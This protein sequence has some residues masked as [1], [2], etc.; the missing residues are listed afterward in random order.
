LANH[1]LTIA[2]PG[3]TG[4]LFKYNT[5]DFAPSPSV[6]PGKT[7]IH[8]TVNHLRGARPTVSS[9]LVTRA[10]LSGSGIPSLSYSVEDNVDWLSESPASGASTG[11]PVR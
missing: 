7:D 3:G 6:Q 2:L 1:R 10:G 4:R 8:I 9:F 11:E 5:G